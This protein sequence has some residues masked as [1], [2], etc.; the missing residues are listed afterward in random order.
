MKEKL[1]NKRIPTLLGIGFILLGLTLITFVIGDRT[2]LTGRASNSE[3]PQDIKITNL[4]DTAFTVTYRT[5]IPVTGS[6]HYG[7]N[8][9]LGKI[10]IDDLDKD[11]G[12][13]TPRSIHS[14]TLETLSPNTNYYF[15]ILSGSGTFLNNGFQ[16]EVL[17]GPTI[18]SPSS[19]KNTISGKIILPDGNM[20]KESIMYLQT[21]DS[22]VLSRSIKNDGSFNFVLES[23]LHQDLSS[24]VELDNSTILELSFVSNSLQSTALVSLSQT[25]LIPTIALGNNYDFTYKDSYTNQDLSNSEG[26][27]PN[28]INSIGNTTPQLLVPEKSQSFTDQRPQFKGTGL[29]NEEIQITIHSSE[30]IEVKVTTDS[31]GNW[32]YRPENDLSAGEHTIIVRSRNSDGI[33]TT[34]MQSFTVLASGTQVADAATPSATPTLAITLTPTSTPILTPTLEPTISLSPIATSTPTLTQIPL[35]TPT[36][37][38]PVDLPPTG[39]TN[40]LLVLAAIASIVV[41]FVLFLAARTVSL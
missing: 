35:P 19:L 21:K 27:P 18:T 38:S 24:Y 13:P 31:N 23:L 6:I 1:L 14:I 32:T 34:L 41:G 39:N 15:Q 22:Q 20:P 36:L 7:D 3:K 5:D 9:D 11:T 12:A 40:N 2:G 29:P 4:S 26:F 25:D 28:V 16:F 8:I 37:Q 10:E 33:L 30:N 17:T